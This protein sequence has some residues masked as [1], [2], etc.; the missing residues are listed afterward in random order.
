[1][2]II[3]DEGTLLSLRRLAVTLLILYLYAPEHKLIQF[4]LTKKKSLWKTQQRGMTFLISMLVYTRKMWQDFFFGMKGHCV[5]FRSISWWEGRLQTS[6]LISVFP[7]LSHV[8]PYTGC[9]VRVKITPKSS[10]LM[11]NVSEQVRPRQY[12]THFTLNRSVAATI[13]G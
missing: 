10:V 3:W 11:S 5:R 9:G 6:V 4:F 12:V 1:M 13:G 8:L 7:T 2:S